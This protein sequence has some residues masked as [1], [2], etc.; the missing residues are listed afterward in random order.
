MIC[1]NVCDLVLGFK[2]ISLQL[3]FSLAKLDKKQ[4]QECNSLQVEWSG[5]SGHH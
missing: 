2:K 1:A 3:L 5:A 4:D